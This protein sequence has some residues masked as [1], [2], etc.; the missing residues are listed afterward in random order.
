MENCLFNTSRHWH[1]Y[2]SPLGIQID[3]ASHGLELHGFTS[4]NK[5][6]KYI[7]L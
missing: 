4:K 6:K 7:K 5:I 3:P 1:T 2:P